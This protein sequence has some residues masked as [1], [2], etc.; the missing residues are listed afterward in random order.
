MP[1]LAG[2]VKLKVPPGTQSGTVL[3][4]RG[5]GMPHLNRTGRY[6]DQHVRVNVRIPKAGK[7]SRPAWEQLR[8]LDGESPSLF[9]RVRDRFG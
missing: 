9:E 5:K 7:K 4:L 2:K 1:T 8:E 3:R 6:G